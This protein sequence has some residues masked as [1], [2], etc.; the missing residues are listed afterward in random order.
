MERH[1]AEIRNDFRVLLAPLIPLFHIPLQ[2][3]EVVN[4][5]HTT[6]SDGGLIRVTASSASLQ[7][8][9][10]DD[11]GDDAGNEADDRDRALCGFGFVV[12]HAVIFFV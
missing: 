9:E 1:P 3:I 4:I 11:D 6:R 7:H 2:E 8:Q 10:N 12:V 5:C